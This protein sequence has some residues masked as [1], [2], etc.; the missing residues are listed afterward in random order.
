MEERRMEIEK[1]RRKMNRDED[2]TDKDDKK[3][4]RRSRGRKR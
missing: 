2:G 3:L 4:R 1:E